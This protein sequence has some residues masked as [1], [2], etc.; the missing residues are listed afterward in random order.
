M[1]LINQEGRV[2]DLPARMEQSGFQMAREV[3]SISDELMSGIP[4][5]VAMN[6]LEASRLRDNILRKFPNA[7]TD[8]QYLELHPVKEVKQKEAVKLITS[9]MTKDDIIETAMANGVKL[10]N[11]E[12]KLVKD[13]LLELVNARYNR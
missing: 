13:K 9:D 8:S 10:S 6:D 5:G 1:F 2:V 12:K 7:I 11:Q 3:L 4:T